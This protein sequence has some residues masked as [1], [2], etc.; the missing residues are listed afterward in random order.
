MG[1]FW[2]QNARHVGD[3]QEFTQVLHPQRGMFSQGWDLEGDPLAFSVLTGCFSSLPPMHLAIST[4]GVCSPW[5]AVSPAHFLQPKV[6]LRRYWG[7]YLPSLLPGVVP[8]DGQFPN[9][10]G[11]RSSF[12]CTGPRCRYAEDLEPVLRVMAGPGLSK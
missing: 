4:C 11:V 1:T 5:G 3:G 6:Y 2:W 9:A 8:N 10:Q 12:L 7:W